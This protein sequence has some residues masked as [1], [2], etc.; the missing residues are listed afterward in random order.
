[1][2]S[3]RHIMPYSSLR[4]LHF[5]ASQSDQLRPRHKRWKNV[6]SFLYIRVCGQCCAV[7]R[8]SEDWTCLRYGAGS[9]PW[10]FGDTLWYNEWPFRDAPPLDVS[11]HPV[12]C[13]EQFGAWFLSLCPRVRVLRAYECWFPTTTVAS[14]P[15][16]RPSAEQ[17][18]GSRLLSRLRKRSRDL[19]PRRPLEARAPSL[20][21]HFSIGSWPHRTKASEKWIL[22]LA[23]GWNTPRLHQKSEEMCVNYTLIWRRLRFLIQSRF[24]VCL[25]RFI[26]SKR[27]SDK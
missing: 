26:H 24:G 6:V 4:S 8:S 10:H 15:L 7:S 19:R 23:S 18:R 3:D 14:A 2:K 17:G 12:L 27:R 13:S 5:T 16:Y 21:Q 22:A 11:G 25:C 9:E 20:A 1:M